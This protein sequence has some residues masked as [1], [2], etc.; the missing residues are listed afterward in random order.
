M[1]GSETITAD[2]IER[3]RECS[4]ARLRELAAIRE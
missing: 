1:S 3:M 2:V 4:S